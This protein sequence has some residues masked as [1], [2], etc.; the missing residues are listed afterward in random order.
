MDYQARRYRW[1]RAAAAILVTGAAYYFIRGGRPLWPFAWFAPTPVLAFSLGAPA[2]AAAGAAFLAYAIGGVAF[3][4]LAAGIAPGAVVVAF[5]LVGSGVFA[6]AVLL[7]RR[8]VQRLAG[9]QAVFVYPVL[10][11]AWEFLLARQGGTSIAYSQ[12]DFPAVIQ[13]AA[14]VGAPGITFLVSLAASALAV[15]WHLRSQR[16]AALRSLVIPLALC[17]AS[18]AWGAVILSRSSAAPVVR[19]GLAATDETV[20]FFRT[21][22]AEE[23]LWVVGAYARRVGDLAARG[24]EVV[25]LPEKF[26][27]VTPAYAEAVRGVL[28]DAARM[29]HVW[30]V[31]GLN[32]ID[33]SARRNVAL[34]FAPDGRLALEYDKVHMV[35]GWE[36]GYTS[37]QRFPAPIPSQS[38]W[39]VAI[40]RDLNYTDIARANALAGVRLLLVPAWDFV[41]DGWLGARTAALR[42]VENGLAVVRPAQE[43]LVV[44]SDEHGRVLAEV[45]T[46][47]VREAMLVVD[48]PLGS[49]PTPYA[50]MGD[51]FGWLATA[52]AAGI[53][54]YL[55]ARRP[56]TAQTGC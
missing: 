6:L 19:V 32:R 14:L 10:W 49:G 48:V 15:A 1:L 55:A 11:T 52:L 56:R 53:V 2:R 18:I 46:S 38:T 37:G 54:V 36:D 13:V 5:L 40:C 16:R 4:Q 44:A 50:R 7:A 26:V 22:R 41:R 27:G 24:A 33:G 28:A 23:A 47:D 42:A 35:P 39:G 34:I 45:A 25:V 43:G 51:W 20:R 8:A 29:H 21:E 17:T 3:A 12:M 30:V 9:W 31:A